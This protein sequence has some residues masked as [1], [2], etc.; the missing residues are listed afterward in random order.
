MKRRPETPAARELLG[1][2][3]LVLMATAAWGLP[4][5]PETTAV[6]PRVTALPISEALVVDGRLD[7]PAWQQ[8]EV[9]GHFIQRDPAPGKP[10]TETTEFQVAYTR[11]TLYLAI[12]AHTDHGAKLIAGEMQR[13][14]SLFRDDSVLILLDTFNDHRNAY[15]FETNA[16]GARTDALVTDEG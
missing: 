3:L 2:S 11:S 6:R 10:A 12:R 4:A 8:A 9:A 5:A 7:E 14:G 16:N 15:W 1:G 13:D